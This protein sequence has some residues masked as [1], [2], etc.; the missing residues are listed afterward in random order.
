MLRRWVLLRHESPK[1]IKEKEP[2]KKKGS[3]DYFGLMNLSLASCSPAELA[4]VSIQQGKNQ[5]EKLYFKTVEKA[6]QIHKLLT[7]RQLDLLVRKGVFRQ[8]DVSRIWFVAG[9][10]V[11]FFRLRFYLFKITKTLSLAQNP[12]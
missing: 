5:F 4:S 7:V 2:L 10:K 3:I 9:K 12:P 6:D 8:I 1:V 11:E